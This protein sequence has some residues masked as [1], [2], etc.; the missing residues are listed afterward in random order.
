MKKKKQKLYLCDVI[1]LCAVHF[2][3]SSIRQS[4]DT[5][6]AQYVRR[7][8]ISAKDNFEEDA[9]EFKGEFRETSCRCCR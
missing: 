6:R 7:N 3:Y 9:M 1:D 8:I 5:E 4:R 2:C